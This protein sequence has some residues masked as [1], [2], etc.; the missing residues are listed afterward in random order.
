MIII[1]I[2]I[3]YISHVISYLYILYIYICIVYTISSVICVVHI[4]GLGFPD[5]LR[6]LR[7]LQPVASLE[8]ALTVLEAS[9]VPFVQLPFPGKKQ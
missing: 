3:I 8:T 2:Y 9:C 7:L 6:S 4:S 1:Y 5:A